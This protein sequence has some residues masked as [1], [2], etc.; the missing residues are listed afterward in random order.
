MDSNS[1]KSVQS[2][3]STR[4]QKGP[5]QTRTRALYQDKD[6]LNYGD[7]DGKLV[8]KFSHGLELMDNFN[9]K[10]HRAVPIMRKSS[11]SKMNVKAQEKDLP[12]P[13]PGIWSGFLAKL[14]CVKRPD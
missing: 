7:P 9:K 8:L 5:A 10:R 13:S 12:T 3:L 2:S 14:G 4:D 11:Q 1:E 6:T